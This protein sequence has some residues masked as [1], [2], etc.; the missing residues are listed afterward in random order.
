M[1]NNGYHL[2]ERDLD[3][4]ESALRLLKDPDNPIPPRK[5]TA[6]TLIQTFL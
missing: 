6:Y 4:L 5:I 1:V 2:S 3:L